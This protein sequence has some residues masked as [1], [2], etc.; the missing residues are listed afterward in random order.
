MEHADRAIRQN[1][2][3]LRQCAAIIR[4]APPLWPLWWP[5]LRACEAEAARLERTLAR[6]PH[7]SAELAWGEVIDLRAWRRRK[8]E[9]LSSRRHTAGDV[10]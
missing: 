3:C 7:A 2:G 9:T 5:V 8:A 4:F 6:Q 1:I 10:A